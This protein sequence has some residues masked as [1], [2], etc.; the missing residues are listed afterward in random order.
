MVCLF[1]LLLLQVCPYCRTVRKNRGLVV[2]PLVTVGFV[3]AV[4]AVAAHLVPEV[5]YDAVHGRLEALVQA[6]QLSRLGVMEWIAEAILHDLP[7]LGFYFV[8]HFHYLSIWVAI[9]LVGHAIQTTVAETVPYLHGLHES[10][11]ESPSFY[12]IVA[13][14]ELPCPWHYPFFFRHGYFIFSSIAFRL[15]CTFLPST[16]GSMV[17]S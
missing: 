9:G 11:E 4:F 1:H 15:L 12:Y 7:H 13:C 6:S 2:V 14:S 17:V 10:F 3:A 16:V 5:V 8:V